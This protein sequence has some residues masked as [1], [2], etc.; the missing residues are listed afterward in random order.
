MS[1][2]GT[3]LFGAGSLDELA[4][5]S[6]ALTPA[7]IADHAATVP[8]TTIV[9]G[10]SG[11]TSDAT[12]RFASDDSAAS[13]ECRIDAE[14][15]APCTSPAS[16]PSLSLGPHTFEVRAT[17]QLGRTDATPASRSFTLVPPPVADPGYSATSGSV[18]PRAANL[19]SLRLPIKAASAETYSAALRRCATKHGAARRASC[20]RAA[21]ARLLPTM[22]FT[23]DREARV[24]FTLRRWSNNHTVSFAINGATGRNRVRWRP[25]VG[26][27]KLV[28]GTYTLTV[29]LGTGAA[30]RV[31][32][33]LTVKVS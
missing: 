5:Y 3:S 12:F 30:T 14:V 31:V 9:A 1:R 18:G 27:Q 19:A 4:I 8:D 13:F 33:S 17:S 6:R 26:A 2:G 25:Q 21:V 23:L 29:K 11:T 32:D 22:S 10:P 28:A 24:T 7:E 15:F 16:H 20:R